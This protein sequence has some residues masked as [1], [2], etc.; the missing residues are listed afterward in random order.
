MRK[1]KIIATVGPASHSPE[2]LL[3]LIESGV[4]VV[5]LNFS[6]GTAEQHKE[7]ADR[8]R[9]IAASLNQH[10]AVL[11]DLQGPKIRISTFKADKVNLSAGDRFYLDGTLAAEAGD[12]TQVGLDYPELIQDLV[13]DHILL[14]DDGRMQLRVVSVDRDNQRVETV[15][16]NDGVLSNRKGINLLGGGLSAP[17]LTEKDKRD[18]QTAAEIDADFVAVSFPRNGADIDEARRLL[19]EAGSDADIVAKVERAEVVASEQAMD[20]VI[21]ASDIIMVARGDLG[22]EVGDARLPVVQKQLI[23]RAQYHGK[24]VITA[25]QMMESMIENPLPTRAEVLD[26]ANA[27]ID[28]TD[29]VMLSAESASGRYPVESVQ[30]LVRIANGAEKDLLDQRLWAELSH[31]CTTPDEAVAVSS[32]LGMQGVHSQSA[33]NRHMAAVCLTESGRTARLLSRTRTSAPILAVSDQLKTL[34]RLTILR[35]ITPVYG[36]TATFSE[37][38]VITAAQAHWLN[39]HD[40][41]AN[42]SFSGQHSRAAGTVMVVNIENQTGSTIRLIEVGKPTVD[43]KVTDSE[44]L[45]SKEMDTAAA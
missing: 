20:D 19:L 1:T 27:I 26:V 13:P 3:Q 42:Q 40:G 44:L 11:V 33:A 34:R 8:V 4:N 35:G 6:H 45:I 5:R 28:G 16:L 7:V 10:V 9:Q 30:A 21:L 2:V 37:Q 12:Q 15:V 22:V 18:I 38:Q 29:A 31:L 36:Q 23:A 14:L 24:P 17:A 32:V 39:H 25:T 41:T 43:V